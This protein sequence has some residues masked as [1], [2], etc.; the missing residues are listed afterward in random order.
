MEG[1]QNMETNTQEN[2]NSGNNSGQEK[3]FTQEEVNRIIGERLSR[4]KTDSSQ[5]LQERERKATA[6]EL[7]L[8]AREKLM[9]AGLPKELLG[10]INCSTKEAMENSIKVIQGLYGGDHSGN[11]QKPVYRISTGVNNQ[12]NGSHHVSGADDPAAIRKAMGLK[13]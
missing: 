13:G 12:S 10:A 4:V 2:Q 8:D 11:S 3:L 6:R 7:Q 9:D 1:N 5:E